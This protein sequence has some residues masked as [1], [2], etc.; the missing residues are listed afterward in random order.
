VATCVDDDA[1]CLYFAPV[2]L[3]DR[4]FFSVLPASNGLRPP[5]VADEPRNHEVDQAIA[6]EGER[7]QDQSQLFRRSEICDGHGTQAQPACAKSDRMQDET[8]EP[9]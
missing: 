1:C 7:Q 9:T 2:P 4:L 5:L 8:P 3:R 6:P